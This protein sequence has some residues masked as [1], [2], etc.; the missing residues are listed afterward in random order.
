M[1]R[2]TGLQECEIARIKRNLEYELLNESIFPNEDMECYSEKIIIA[3]G[4]AEIEGES[5]VLVT[6]EPQNNRIA[7][8]I[9]H[10]DS[11][12]F[13]IYYTDNV[14]CEYNQYIVTHVEVMEV[15]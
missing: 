1:G 5:E 10:I 15:N 3:F 9:N 4:D 8:Y 12:I 7:A 11:Q 2:L 14:N 13:Y 6:H